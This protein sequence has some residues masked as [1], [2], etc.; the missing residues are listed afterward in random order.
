VRP[1]QRAALIAATGIALALGAPSAQ[2]A[3]SQPATGQVGDTFACLDGTTNY[4]SIFYTIT[5]PTE[6]ELEGPNVTL[7]TIEAVNPCAQ[8]ISGYIGVRDRKSGDTFQ[9]AFNVS[10]GSNQTVHRH[11]L[12][13]QGLNK[14]LRSTNSFGSASSA[15]VA[16]PG[17][18]LVDFRRR[19]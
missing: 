19:G 15:A 6:A 12:E 17:V 3:T 1:S 9:L 18:V 11:R 16:A 4:A 5:A 14:R 10:A 13:R 7:T 8:T 2:A